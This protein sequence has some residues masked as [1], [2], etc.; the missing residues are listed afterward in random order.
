MILK[1]LI[2]TMI[3]P[4]TLLVTGYHTEARHF[5]EQVQTISSC[6]IILPSDELLMLFAVCFWQ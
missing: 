5:P 6:P 3:H 2:Y 1:L 4:M